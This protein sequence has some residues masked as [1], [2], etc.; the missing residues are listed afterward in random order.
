MDRLYQMN[1]QTLTEL[2]QGLDVARQSVAQHL[3]LLQAANLVTVIWRGREKH[4]YFNPVPVHE[5]Y[6]RWI[7]K[8]ERQRL[9]AL[10]NFKNKL[11]GGQ[12]E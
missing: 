2:C 6:E 4:H 5:I 12:D 9:R 8:H 3:D 1:S 7:G 11:E 10:Y